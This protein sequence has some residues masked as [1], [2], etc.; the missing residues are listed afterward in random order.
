MQHHRGRKSSAELSIVPVSEPQRPDPPAEFEAVEAEVWQQT[1]AG[2]RADWFGPETR[3]ILTAYC[4]E[5]AIAQMAAQNLRG[6]PATDRHYR[7]FCSI[8]ARATTATIRLATVMRITPQASRRSTR[9]ARDPYAG[10][11]P[12]DDE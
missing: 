11:K 10:P 7:K 12:W 2:M 6:L 3:A 5:V 9:D 4:V 8:H 1:V